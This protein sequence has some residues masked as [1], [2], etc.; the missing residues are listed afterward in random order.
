MTFRKFLFWTHLT[1]GSIAGVVIFTMCV[2]GVLL[3]YQRQILHFAERSYRA[4]PASGAQ[5]L[6]LETL[7]DKAHA[8]QP[9]APASLIWRSSPDEPVEISFGRDQSLLLNPCTGAI[10]GVGATHTRAFFH[11]AEG[12]H[13]GLAFGPEKRSTGR[14]IT[15]ACNLGFLLLVCSGPFL[16]LPRRWSSASFKAGTRFNG[17]L[18]GR[19]R[20]FNWHSVIGFWCCIPLAAI[21]LCAVVTSYPWANHLVYRLTNSPIPAPN[22]QVQVAVAGSPPRGQYNRGDD[23][24]AAVS[25]ASPWHGLDIL[26]HHAEQRVPGWQTIT[27]RLTPSDL[28]LTFAIDTGNGGR[29]D[30]RSQLTMNRNTA[31]EVRYEPFSSF[32]SGRQLRTWIRFTHTGEAGGVLGETIAAIAA[33][34]GA[35]LVWTGLS[36]AIRRLRTTLTRR[37]PAVSAVGGSV[38]AIPPQ[39]HRCEAHGSENATT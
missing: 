5:P 34:G 8:T 31:A 11:S 15:A 16:W 14:A 1:V 32:N 13:R 6:P 18:K 30:K 21:V 10:L 3:A 29:P 35:F 25:A 36:L 33:T 17:R 28:N 19:A 22:G 7:L 26:R 27:L 24:S 39:P 20:D 23:S 4:A 12:V 9:S 38:S 2:T 37:A